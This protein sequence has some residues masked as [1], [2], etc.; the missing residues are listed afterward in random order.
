MKSEAAF[1]SPNLSRSLLMRTQVRTLTL[2]HFRNYHSARIEAAGQSIVLIGPNG[3][4]KTNV[5][6]ALSLL[7]PG[8]GLR[9]ATIQE[10]ENIADHLPWAVAAEIEGPEGE[11]LIGTGRDPESPEDTDKRITKV[12]GKLCAARRGWLSFSRALA[13][14]GYGHPVHRRRYGEAEIP[15]QACL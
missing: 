4:G 7:S 10:M 14:A 9:R 11:A 15:G 5:L 8:R 6:E 2:S 3:A 12:D 1:L 13:Y